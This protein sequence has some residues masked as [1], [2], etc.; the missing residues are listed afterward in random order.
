M[1]SFD[2]LDYLADDPPE[3][4]ALDSKDFQKQHP[5]SRRISEVRSMPIL[6]GPHIPQRQRE[7]LFWAMA[8][9]PF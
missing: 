6:E 9:V 5:H 3:E 1:R 7:E 2:E 4:I 8:E